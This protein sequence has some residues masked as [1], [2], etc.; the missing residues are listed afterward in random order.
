MIKATNSN[1]VNKLDYNFCFNKKNELT[2]LGP[3]C[4]LC[5]ILNGGK[6]GNFVR[7]KINFILPSPNGII[8]S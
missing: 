1:G 5:T 3:N 8:S 6:E 7:P 2:Y 4:T